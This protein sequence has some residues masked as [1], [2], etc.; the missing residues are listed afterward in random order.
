MTISSVRLN[1][2]IFCP[3]KNLASNGSKPIGVLTRTE[4]FHSDLR[5]PISYSLLD[6]QPHTSNFCDHYAAAAAA[7]AN[8]TRLRRG[9]TL[10]VETDVSLMECAFFKQMV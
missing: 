10:G 9:S 4:L 8:L 5:L 1:L 7:A 3:K 6:F 2:V